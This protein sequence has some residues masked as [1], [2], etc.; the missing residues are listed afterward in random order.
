VLLRTGSDS[1]EARDVLQ[2]LARTGET[3]SRVWAFEA[4]GEWGSA[5]AFDLGDPE[6]AIRR[7]AS[8]TLARIDPGR[9][10]GPLVS[11]LALRYFGRG[12]SNP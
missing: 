10:L 12:S 3:A 6:P 5:A 9:S 7:V 11:A 1:G 2:T 8:T 4:L